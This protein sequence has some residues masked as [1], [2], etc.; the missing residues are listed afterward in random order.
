MAEE[1]GGLKANLKSEGWTL[2]AVARLIIIFAISLPLIPVQFIMVKLLP[3]LWW[4]VAGVW[5]RT[6]CRILGIDVRVSSGSFDAHESHKGPV[7][8]AVNHISWLD[9]LVLGGRL[10][11][12]SF[13]AKSE[14]ATW[15]FVGTL[16]QLHKTVYVNRARRSDSARQRDMLV[17]RVR[18]GD[19]LILFPEGTSTDGMRVSPFKSALFSVAERA[20]EAC[21][22][23]LLIQPVT[24]AYTEVNGMPLVRSQKPWVAWLGD[25]ELFAHLR[26]L[27]GRARIEALVEFHAPV[28][29]AEAGSR[30]ALAAYCEQE[31]RLGLERALRSERR[32]GPQIVPLEGDSDAV[33][34]DA[35][36]DNTAEPA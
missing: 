4:P 34:E 16:S 23:E 7:L 10:E 19:S 20:D 1:Y 35:L 11:N 22:H 6:V 13:V 27:M 5:H 33:L 25:V 28:T 30:K 21:D 9:I 12:A 32:H 15:G 29:V 31:V 14:V 36:F 2:L 17:D 18:Q 8:Y 26:Q 24:L 3:S